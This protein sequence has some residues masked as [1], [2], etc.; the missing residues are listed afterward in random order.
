MPLELK[1]SEFKQIRDYIKEH[2]GIALGDEKSTLVFSRLRPLLRQKGFADFSEYIKYLMNDRTGEAAVVFI[3]RLTT[4]HTFFMREPEHIIFLQNTVL[5]WI[6]DKFG[7]QRDLR[8]WCAGCS[9]GEEAY[10]LQMAC[11]DY[12][13]NMQGWDTEILA[14]DISEK[15][16]QQATLGIYSN[17]SL[18]TLPGEWLKKHFR[19]YD[20]DNMIACDEIKKLITYRKFNLMEER[21]PFKKKFQVIFC[22]NV[23]IYFDNNTREALVNRFYGALEKDG[24][25]F[26]GHSE[27]LSNVKS[28]FKYVM[29]AVYKK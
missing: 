3:N 29:P 28:D 21:L 5:P 2:Y 13:Q 9:S 19:R 23:M 17:E 12:F 11:M 6:E 7:T 16:L 15:V 4:N 25:L 27:S 8:L 1:N 22:R 18:K 14:T 10:T 20:D 24:Y 26:I